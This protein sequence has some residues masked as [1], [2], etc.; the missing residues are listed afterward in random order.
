MLPFFL[1]AA[2]SRGPHSD[3]LPQHILEEFLIQ[4]SRMPEKTTVQGE[5]TQKSFVVKAY[6]GEAKGMQQSHTFMR[7]IDILARGIKE[8]CP[9]KGGSC[10]IFFLTQGHLFCY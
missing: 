8:L 4:D 2:Q 3:S 9:L 5:S 7:N 1:P 6:N 10:A